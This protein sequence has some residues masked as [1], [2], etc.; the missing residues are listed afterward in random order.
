MKEECLDHAR[1]SSQ[2]LK[3]KKVSRAEVCGGGTSLWALLRSLFF[4]CVLVGY[5]GTGGSLPS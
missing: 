3:G 4:V 1:F 5:S 2:I